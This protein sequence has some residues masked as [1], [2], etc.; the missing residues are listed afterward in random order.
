MRHCTAHEKAHRTQVSPVYVLVLLR[1]SVLATVSTSR[2]SFGRSQN[3]SRLRHV[4]TIT[5]ESVSQ[6]ALVIETVE[7]APSRWQRNT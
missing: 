3:Q 2:R 5:D 7:I 1:S 4:A 6:L